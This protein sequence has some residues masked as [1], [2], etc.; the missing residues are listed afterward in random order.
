MVK[1]AF[2]LVAV[3]ACFFLAQFVTAALWTGSGTAED[4]YNITDCD[5][6]QGVSTSLGSYFQLQNNIDCSDTIT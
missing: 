6:L 4:P 2:I 5:G 1:G 3:I